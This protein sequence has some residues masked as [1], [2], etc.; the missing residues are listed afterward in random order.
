MDWKIIIPAILFVSLL[1]VEDKSIKGKRNMF[2]NLQ[3][4][5]NNGENSFPQFLLTKLRL[6]LILCGGL[7]HDTVFVLQWELNC[8]CVQAEP[9]STVSAS[10]KSSTKYTEKYN[11][12]GMTLLSLCPIYCCS[13]SLLCH[14]SLSLVSGIVSSHYTLRGM[15]YSTL[16]QAQ[17]HKG[18]KGT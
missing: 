14:R 15:E 10:L 18:L 1:S 8:T 13:V 9:G 12:P 3:K 6:Q 4:Q 7:I 2:P 16:I 11:V 17:R 5:S